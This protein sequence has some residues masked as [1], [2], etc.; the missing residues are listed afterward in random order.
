MLSYHG[1]HS[2]RTC[3]R[4]QIYSSFVLVDAPRRNVST[5]LPAARHEG[6]E[7]Q[8]QRPLS[9]RD[10]LADVLCLSRSCNPSPMGRTA[11]HFTSPDRYH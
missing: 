6:L 11:D 5:T 9:L 10:F 2:P 4:Q 7:V 1:F 3:L 8:T